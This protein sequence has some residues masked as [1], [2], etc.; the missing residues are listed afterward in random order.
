MSQQDEQFESVVYLVSDHLCSAIEE[1][2]EIFNLRYRPDDISEDMS[3]EDILTR[4]GGFHQFLDELR[5]HEFML[6]NK[7]NQTRHWARNLRSLD[8][9][10]K[11]VIDLFITGTAIISDASDVLSQSN[12]EIFHGHREPKHLLES[13]QLITVA[14]NDDGKA[15]RIM[16]DQSYLLN[17]KI[18]LSDLMIVC[19]TF[20]E[21]LHARYSSDED[22]GPSNGDGTQESLPDGTREQTSSPGPLSA[23]RKPGSAAD[24]NE[25][26]A[27]IYRLMNRFRRSG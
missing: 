10:F 14:S 26:G 5:T 20:L 16:A 7:I 6:V 23:L 18:P 22:E 25:K 27:T 4:L 12:E 1:G 8:P 2:D 9:S 21:S 19:T 11:P 17:G 3:A 13:R 15:A 24:S